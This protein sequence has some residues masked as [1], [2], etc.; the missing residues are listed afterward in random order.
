[1]SSDKPTSSS[2]VWSGPEYSQEHGHHYVQPYHSASPQTDAYSQSP[3]HPHQSPVVE[4]SADNTV[5][6]ELDSGQQYQRH[7]QK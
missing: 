4:M 1:M 2:G 3:P 6:Q 7:Q 5:R